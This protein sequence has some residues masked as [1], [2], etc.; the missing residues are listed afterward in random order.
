ME[1]GQASVRH[2]LAPKGPFWWGHGGSPT[3]A[4]TATL[5]DVLPDAASGSAWVGMP[6]ELRREPTVPNHFRS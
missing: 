3:M 1:C 4:A 2:E 6:H 5:D